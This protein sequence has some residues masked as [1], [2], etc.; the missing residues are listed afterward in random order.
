MTSAWRWRSVTRRPELGAVPNATRPLER[1]SGNLPGQCFDHHGGPI[2]RGVTAVTSAPVPPAPVA[3][4][5]QA[6]PFPHTQVMSLRE[7][8]ERRRLHQERVDAWLGPHLERRRR[9]E[10]HPVEDF[11]FT[12]YSFRPA[13]LRRWHPGLGVVL[14]GADPAELGPHYVLTPIPME[15]PAG[16]FDNAAVSRTVDRGARDHASASAYESSPTPALES[17]SPAHPATR[18]AS[19]ATLSFQLLQRRR[20][21]LEWITQL[22]E[23]TAGRTPYFGCFGMHEWAMVYKLPASQ[24]RHAAWP[25]RL[26]EEETARVVEERGVRCSHFD[27]F[28]FFTPPAR[29]L[30]V[31]QPTRELQPE[32]EQPGCLHANMD[33]YKLAYKLSPLVGSDL[34]ADC[35]A[36]ARQIRVLDMRA[37]PYD[38]RGLGLSP[39]CVE[40][41][42][43]RAEFA[44]AQREFAA[45]ATP[46]RDRL[47]AECRRLLAL[48]DALDGVVN[49][50]P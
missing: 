25:L 17:S 31:L 39:V 20:S 21:S 22:L 43:G 41:A 49:G 15:I 42:A 38:L 4:T 19:G 2:L 6:Q 36:L 8:R 7:W 44:A 45:Q 16:V 48:A 33:L 32:L 50:S 24:V 13:Q 35:F 27:A 11:L 3:V 14:E 5:P 46:L 30:N 47:L 23:R 10:K 37:S 40:T 12:Y 26:S 9:G 34:I 28:R 1:L 29:P 18:G